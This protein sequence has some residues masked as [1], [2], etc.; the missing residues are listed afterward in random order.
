[1]IKKIETQNHKVLSKLHNKGFSNK[2]M[3]TKKMKKRFIIIL[4]KDHN[5]KVISFNLHFS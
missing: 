1:M 2:N 4:K 3:K 5:Y